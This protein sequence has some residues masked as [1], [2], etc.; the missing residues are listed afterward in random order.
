VFTTKQ[1]QEV[2]VS[3]QCWSR[4]KHFENVRHLCF[5]FEGLFKNL[6]SL[7]LSLSVCVCVCVCVC[8]RARK[9][10]GV[11]V[12]VEVRRGCYLIPLKLEYKL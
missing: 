10:T 7:S 9:H 2:Q 4:V 11:K 6:L 5:D 12:S 8:A 3:G 1:A